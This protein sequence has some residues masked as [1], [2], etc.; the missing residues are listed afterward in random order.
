MD[1]INQDKMVDGYIESFDGGYKIITSKL[2]A[3][4]ITMN[5]AVQKVGEGG[6]L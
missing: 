6:L 5:M 3:E 2:P 4:D 1:L